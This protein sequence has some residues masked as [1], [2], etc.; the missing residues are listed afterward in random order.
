MFHL[1][2]TRVTESNCQQS[3]ERF[4]LNKAFGLIRIHER[5]RM[6]I[7]WSEGRPIDLARYKDMGTSPN[8]QQSGGGR[9]RAGSAEWRHLLHLTSRHYRNYTIQEE[10]WIGIK[11]Y[12]YCYLFKT[13]SKLPFIT[14]YQSYSFFL[15][16]SVTSLKKAIR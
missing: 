11:L 14:S 6:I 16:K 5:E 10:Y 9:T 2:S 12:F 13:S 3:M 1:I 15:H 4:K 7:V 8:R